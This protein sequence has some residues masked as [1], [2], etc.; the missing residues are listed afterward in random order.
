MTAY[1]TAYV[2]LAE[3]LGATLLTRDER[4]AAG[5]GARARIVLV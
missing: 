2:A 5:P 4:L 3:A 1:D